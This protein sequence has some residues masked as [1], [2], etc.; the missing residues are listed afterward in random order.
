[1]TAVMKKSASEEAKLY[2]CDLNKWTTHNDKLTGS[3]IF[4]S[5]S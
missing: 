3:N 2:I 5:D 4:A 1:M